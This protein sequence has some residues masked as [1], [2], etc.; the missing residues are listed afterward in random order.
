MQARL[1]MMTEAI[2]VRLREMHRWGE[3]VRVESNMAD[4]GRETKADRTTPEAGQ[5]SRVNVATEAEQN[6]TPLSTQ[7]QSG[8]R[9][10]LS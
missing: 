9:S 5:C 1:S 7:H 8:V 3:S 4:L 6:N 2:G 10:D